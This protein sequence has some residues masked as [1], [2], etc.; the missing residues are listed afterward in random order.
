MK[1]D[2]R[3]RGLSSA[4]N[5]FPIRALFQEEPEEDGKSSEEEQEPKSTSPKTAPATEAETAPAPLPDVE[6]VLK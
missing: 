3:E 6:G 1:Y 5:V 4:R 2:P